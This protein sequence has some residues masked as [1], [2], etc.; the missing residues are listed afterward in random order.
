M[1]KPVKSAAYV[2]LVVV[3]V[4]ASILVYA[5]V[6]YPGDY[7]LRILRWG[8]SDVYDYQKFPA[9]ALAASETPFYFQDVPDEAR[10]RAFFN[11]QEAVG[12]LEAFL[13]ET[14]TQAFIVI[15]DD[16][17]LYENYFNGASR[18]SVVTSFSMAKSFTSALVG[19]AIDEGYI[20]S[21]DDPITDYMPELLERDPAFGAITIGDLLLMSSGI[22]YREFPFVNGD[23]AKTYYYPDLQ[24]L[25]LEQTQIASEPG[26]TFLYN[27]YHPLLLGIILERATGRPVAQFLEEKIWQPLGMEYDGSWSLDENGFAK[28]ESGINGRAIDF[29]KFGRLFL[30][31]GDWDG[32]QVI[33]SDWVQEST[34]PYFPKQTYYGSFFDPFPGVG[35]YKYM[36]WGYQ[37]PDGTYDFAAEGNK[38]QFIYISPHK[39]LIIV[40]HGENYGVAIAEWINI[41]Y[42]VASRIDALPAND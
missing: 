39:D 31:K 16:Q 21:L 37:R 38:G 24:E 12:D 18:D 41:L 34:A 19:I 10:I 25:A 26:E 6:F 14:D 8:D 9:Q 20:G 33:S 40:R 13:T 4:I 5:F 30:N 35:Y 17:I 32:D 3:I 36:W 2:L 15:Q 42:D 23:D 27:N 7:V 1:K 11:D 28:M 22:K 29:A